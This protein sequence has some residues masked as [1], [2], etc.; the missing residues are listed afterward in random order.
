MRGRLALRSSELSESETK[1]V[2]EC[3]TL[4]QHSGTSHTVIFPF[5]NVVKIFG[6]RFMFSRGGSGGRHGRQRQ[7]VY[8]IH[9]YC[10][11]R[12]AEQKKQK[13]KAGHSLNQ[14]QEYSASLPVSYCYSSEV[15]PENGVQ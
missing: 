6:I 12:D 5:R 10:G 11:T 14:E 8:I 2:A 9:I 4:K 15:Q 1:R 13:N 7:D 3:Y